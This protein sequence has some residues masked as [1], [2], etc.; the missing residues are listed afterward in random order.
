MA[1]EAVPIENVYLLKKKLATDRGAD[2][3]L[4]GRHLLSISF[5]V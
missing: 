1:A 5:F 2:G 4:T 3:V